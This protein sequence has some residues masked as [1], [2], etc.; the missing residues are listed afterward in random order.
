MVSFRTRR[1]SVPVAWRQL[2]A[3]PA[4][5]VVALVAVAAAVSLVLLLSGP[6]SRDGRTGDDISR[7]PACGRLGQEGTRD[8]V[9]QTSGGSPAKRV[10]VRREDMLAID[11]ASPYRCC[12]HNNK[13]VRG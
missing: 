3:E 11:A 6:S 1:G 2:R 5:L 8:F 4:K 12:A 9:A 10:H 7:P 13:Y